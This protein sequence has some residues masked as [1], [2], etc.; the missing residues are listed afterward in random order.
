[1]AARYELFKGIDK[2]FYFR[3]I[4]VNGE[5]IL[6]SEGYVSKQGAKNGISSVKVNS[7]LDEQYERKTSTNDQYYFVLKGGNWE[8][9][10]VSQMYT[11]R[12]ARETG[13]AS[14]KAN[15][16]DAPTHDLTGE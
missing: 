16:P 15:G 3:L 6:R 1:M 10:G 12:D 9:I 8:I 7:P 2:Q 14:V 5:Q 13:I 4:A 11:T